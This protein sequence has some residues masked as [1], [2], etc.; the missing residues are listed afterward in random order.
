LVL[1]GV[2]VAASVSL[3]A[4][5][6][7]SGES[8]ETSQQTSP[9]TSKGGSAGQ[10]GQSGQTGQAGQTGGDAGADGGGAAGAGAAAGAGDSGAGGDFGEIGGAD[11]SPAA[12][13]D[14]V[15]SHEGQE[16]CD[17]CPQ[18]C[19]ACA[20]CG[21]GTC[22]RDAGESAESCSS[23]E[24]DCG[25]CSTCGDGQCVANS[26]ENCTTCPDDC[27][28][29][30][31]CGDGKCDQNETCSSC[32]KDCGAC[33]TCGNGKCEAGLGE[34]CKTCDEDCG[35]CETCGD[36]ACNGKETCDSC[37]KDCGSCDR[38]G[39]VQGDFDPFWGGLHAHTH[40]SSDAAAKGAGYP[41]EAFQHARNAKP[42]FDF[43]WLSDHHANLSP[44]DF[45]L[46]EAA[47][48]KANKPDD[49]VAGC[50]FEMGVFEGQPFKSK[51][52]GHF[53][54]LFPNQYYKMSFNIPELYNKVAD[55]KECLGQFNHPPKPGTFNQ[56]E[57]KPV[58][59]DRVR[60][61]EFN[62]GP[63]AD[64]LG[65]F[66]K[67]LNN[68]WKVSPSWNEDNHTSN[69]GDSS[70]ATVVWTTKLSRPGIRAGVLANRTVATND[71]SARLKMLADGKCWMGSDLEGLGKSKITVT[72]VDKQ[73]NDVFDNV[74]LYGK[75]GD[76]IGTKSCANKNPCTVDFNIDLKQPGFVFAV[77]R[78][79]DG[80]LLVGAPI[81]YHAK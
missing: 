29:C 73:P 67:A 55:C 24:E 66:V 61:M 74:A 48:N 30:Q 35:A 41:A 57:Y 26:D 77:A 18:D 63:F 58:A 71:D 28:V 20:A 53:N 40:L 76:K 44:A 69:W 2:L 81:W 68:G 59:K 75:S 33:Q 80:N 11:A 38:K 64:H 1:G 16:E 37:A 46:C 13:G 34:T 17:T 56:W 14:G 49:F 62:G 65:P 6:A 79:K 27:G 54:V 39:C 47:A 21:N 7:C 60:L 78:Q 15:C 45:A 23:C 19:G 51:W 4:F 12:C 9:G 36:G 3:G 52:V 22:E 10:T 25:A 8:G 32:K 42:P 5:A 70:V 72:V 31:G 50:G 43:L